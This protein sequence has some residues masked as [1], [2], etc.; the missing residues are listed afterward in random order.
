[1]DSKIVQPCFSVKLFKHQ[2]FINGSIFCNCK[3]VLNITFTFSFLDDDVSKALLADLNKLMQVL[4]CKL[5]IF[6]NRRS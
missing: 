4:T 6:E 2:P 1:M 3:Q 5:S